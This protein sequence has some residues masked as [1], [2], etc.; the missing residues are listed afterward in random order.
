MLTFARAAFR[1]VCVMR[2]MTCREIAPISAV[3]SSVL[4]AI[5]ISLLAAPDAGTPTPM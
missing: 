3:G 5:A 1:Y 4:P 2:S